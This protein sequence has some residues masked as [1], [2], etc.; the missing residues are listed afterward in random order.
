MS[1]KG[2]QSTSSKFLEFCKVN[3]IQHLTSPPFNPLTNGLAENVVKSFKNGIQK[4]CW[5]KGNE[6]VTL[7]TIINRYLLTYRTTV[8]STT[9]ETPT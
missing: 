7:P 4:A 6:N 3:G 1:D 5:D 9:G 8:H 2:P